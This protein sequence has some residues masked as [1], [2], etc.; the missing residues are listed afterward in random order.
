MFLPYE[1]YGLIQS[2]MDIVVE[3]ED[4]IIFHLDSVF[5]L[6]VFLRDSLITETV[7]QFCGSGRGGVLG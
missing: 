3:N 1:E 4:S 2:R 7:D 6:D 5:L